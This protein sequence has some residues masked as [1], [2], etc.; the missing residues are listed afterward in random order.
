MDLLQILRKIWRYR[1][2]TLPVLAL[3]LLGAIYVVAGKESEYS[4]FSSYVLINPPAPPTAEEIAADPSLGRINSDNP[5]TRFTDQ[6]VVMDLLASTLN[7]ESARRALA[8]Q[9]ADNRYTVAS[10]SEFGFSSQLLDVTGV[11]ST[12]GQAV[13]TAELVGAALNSELERLQESRGVAARYRIETQRVVAPDHAEQQVSGKLRTLVGVFALGAILLFVVVSAAE[14]LA[15]LRAERGDGDGPNKKGKGDS[16]RA[17]KWLTGQLTR[18]RGASSRMASVGRSL[19]SPS[20]KDGP[21]KGDNGHPTDLAG[22]TEA[23]AAARA[24]RGE[25]N[26]TGP[27]DNGDSV[28]SRGKNASTGREQDSRRRRRAGSKA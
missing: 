26:G 1:I 5:F 17:W 4:A 16:R 9:G 20:R 28:D 21:G 22:T 12:P 7:N 3:T 14:G 18:L 13:R 8:Q 27:K 6:S 23:L 15:T 11:G 19:S 2:V 10:S 25:G 24:E